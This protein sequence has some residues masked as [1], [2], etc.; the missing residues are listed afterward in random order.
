MSTA[1]LR[2]VV[3]GG[4][5]GAVAGLASHFVMPAP[6]RLPDVGV[7]TSFAA[8]DPQ[9][10]DAL[11]H[12]GQFAA[13]QTAAYK[14][15]IAVSDAIVQLYLQLFEE[16]LTR[17]R[18]VHTNQIKVQQLVTVVKE[19]VDKMRSAVLRK[20]PEEIEHFNE[21]AE[22]YEAV[23]HAYFDNIFTDSMDLPAGDDDAD[24]ALIERLRGRRG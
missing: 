18:Y 1:I 23:V 19:L 8:Q 13:H 22:A 15:I 9:V 5:L 4:A 17:S 7:S 2:K 14:Q 12:L 11:L 10:V 16:P 24:E 3:V 20:A 6:E 21:A